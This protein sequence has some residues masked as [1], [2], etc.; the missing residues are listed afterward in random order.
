MS[1]KKKELSWLE[2]YDASQTK[3][4]SKLEVGTRFRCGESVGVVLVVDA[5]RVRVKWDRDSQTVNVAPSMQCD[6]I[7]GMEEII[8]S[9]DKKVTVKAQQKERPFF[10]GW[11]P[12]KLPDK[13]VRVFKE[14]RYSVERVNGSWSVN[15]NKAVSIREA[16]TFILSKHGKT[17]GRTADNFFR[18]IE[19]SETKAKEKKQ[20][21]AKS[22]A[23]KSV[24]KNARAAKK[25]KSV[26][27]RKK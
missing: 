16:M 9:A 17:T 4:V 11:T 7:I 2:R 20:S 23:G 26:M 27:K 14:T 12:D 21:S 10:Q 13:F 1:S 19:T 18:T 15:G 24:K 6:E 22:T 3:S 8:M 25:V 5:G